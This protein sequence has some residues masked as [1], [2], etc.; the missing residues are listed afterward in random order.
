MK[1]YDQ[2]C[3]VGKKFKIGNSPFLHLAKEG[4]F[5]TF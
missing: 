4:D 1:S 2:Y 5:A 3:Q